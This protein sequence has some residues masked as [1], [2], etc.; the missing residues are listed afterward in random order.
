MEHNTENNK[1]SQSVISQEKNKQD[2]GNT[3]LMMFIYG[4]AGFI[5]IFILIFALYGVVRVYAQGA[6]DKGTTIVATVLRLPLAKVNGHV[7]RYSEYLSDLKAIHTL[8]EYE[9]LNGG[10]TVTLDETQMSDQVI[11]RL[12]NNI[13]ISELGRTYNI[14]VTN[15]EILNLKAQMIEQ[16]ASEEEAEEELM[17]R[18][19][20]TMGIYE[21]KVIKPYLLQQKIAEKLEVDPALRED[22]YNRAQKILEEILG[23]ANFE[24]MANKYGEDGTAMNGGDLGWFGKG[25]MVPQ[26][27]AA[28]FAL[29]KDQVSQEL[30]ETPFGYHIIKVDE[31]SVEK[32]KDTTSGKMV[33]VE[34]IS[35]RH[36]VFLFPSLEASLDK[37][38]KNAQVSWYA[39]KV[40]NPLSE[41]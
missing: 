21:K 11:W 26:F 28:A 38:L 3:N 22:V 24:E 19:G 23:G 14:T 34:R 30:V 8:N 12:V 6:T 10:L 17:K 32:E 9:K 41:L 36:I 18:Y 33:D 29:E 39:K 16:F 13:I 20:W 1:V 27:E 37:S 15:D 7:I 5:G 25:D 40:H 35:A 4:F 31:K 2:K